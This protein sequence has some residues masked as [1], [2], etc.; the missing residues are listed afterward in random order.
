MLVFQGEPKESTGAAADNGI[1]DDQP[2]EDLVNETKADGSTAGGATAANT[3]TKTSEVNT[4]KGRLVVTT[5]ND[6]TD[7][8]SIIIE[9]P[10]GPDG[11]KTP[12]GEGKTVRV[13]V[14]MRDR[15]WMRVSS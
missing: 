12:A 5:T 6:G 8:K 10:S 7:L 3:T 15:M 11:N 9:K 2:V 13:R 14:H 1:S 4:A